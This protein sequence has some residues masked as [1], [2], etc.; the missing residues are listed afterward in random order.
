MKHQVSNPG[1][2]ALIKQLGVG[3]LALAGFSTAPSAWAKNNDKLWKREGTDLTFKQLLKR[4]AFPIGKNSTGGVKGS[5]IHIN[6]ELLRKAPNSE[7]PVPKD[8]NIHTLCHS[9][10][11]RTDF[12]K[13]TRWYQED[14]STQVFRLFKDEHNVRNSRKNA[15]R[16]EAFSHLA[17]ERGGWHAWQGTYTVIK[18]HGAMIFQAKNDNN[19]WGVSIGLSEDGDIRLNHRRGTDKTIARNMTGKRFTLGVRDNGH[20]YEVYYNKEKVGEGT[21]NRPNGKTKFRW[22]MYVGD[23]EVRHDAMLFVTGVR[24]E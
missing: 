22:G 7:K 11:K 15:A 24:L 3:A 19:D 6:H 17:W 10:I 9:S 18:P 5:T 23:N 12:P 21:Y 16:I 8:I 14:G 13:W 2:R 1:R 20:D 4:R